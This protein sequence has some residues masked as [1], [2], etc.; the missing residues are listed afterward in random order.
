VSDVSDESEAS[1]WAAY[2]RA[3]ER[4]FGTSEEDIAFY[5]ETAGYAYGNYLCGPP[6][7]EAVSWA[8]GQYTSLWSDKEEEANR[9]YTAVA[10]AD[11]ETQQA[12]FS[13]LAAEFDLMISS[14]ESVFETLGIDIRAAQ[15]IEEPGPLALEGRC[16]EYTTGPD[17]WQRCSKRGEPEQLTTIREIANIYI[18]RLTDWPWRDIPAPEVDAPNTGSPSD[19]WSAWDRWVSQLQSYVTGGGSFRMVPG[20]AQERAG[21]GALRLK[22]VAENVIAA[23]A[24]ATS[25]RAAEIAAADKDDSGATLA[26]VAV[27]GLAI[28]GSWWMT[29]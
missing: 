9:R 1:Y 13:A 25:D 10:M 2:D 8:V 26:V 11:W 21:S 20:T 7:G 6:C 22:N 3:K 19:T 12:V 15:W 28:L 18:Q 14:V 24:V 16:I 23:S 17:G 5:L 4:G 29:R 27:G